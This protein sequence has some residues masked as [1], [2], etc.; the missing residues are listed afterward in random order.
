VRGARRVGPIVI[1]ALVARAAGAGEA[2]PHWWQPRAQ[3]LPIAR[4]AP[5][6]ATERVDSLPASAPR[7]LRQLDHTERARPYL[8]ALREFGLLREAI[9]R[10]RTPSVLAAADPGVGPPASSHSLDFDA[11]AREQ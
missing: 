11:S 6:A 7:L 1:A 8:I 10:P 3:P 4:S 9:P 2:D 5:A